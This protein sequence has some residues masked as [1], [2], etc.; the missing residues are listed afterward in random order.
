M[1]EAYAVRLFLSTCAARLE[2]SL[3]HGVH[4]GCLPEERVYFC[5]S[6]SFTISRC[7][8]DLKP[9]KILGIS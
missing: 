1:A 4:A 9:G 2:S 7:I 3:N 5:E 8:F 6:G